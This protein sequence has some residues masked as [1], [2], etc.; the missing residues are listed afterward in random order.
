MSKG[1][2]APAANLP[3]I[4]HFIYSTPPHVPSISDFDMQRLLR[5]SAASAPY[6]YNF[7]SEEKEGLSYTG[8]QA[9]GRV[10]SRSHE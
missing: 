6:F 9:Q 2:L 5:T 3:T 7:I 4:I 8:R 1:V 10:S